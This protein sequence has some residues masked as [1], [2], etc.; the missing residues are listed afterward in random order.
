MNSVSQHLK[1]LVISLNFNPGHV[2]HMIASYKQ[3]EELNY[4][5]AYYVNHQFVKFLPP[6]SSVIC[7]GQEF[8]P[9]FMHIDIAIFLF[10]SL[11]NLSLMWKLKRNGTKIVYVFHEPLTS[12]NVYRKAGFSFLYLL[13]LQLIDCISALAVKLSNLILLPSY[14]AIDYY[15]SNS[16]YKNSNYHYLPLM[17]DDEAVDDIMSYSR[18]YFSYIGTVAADHSFNEFLEFVSWAIKENKLPGLKFLIATKS[19][20]AVPELLSSSSRVVI[21]K[22]KPMTNNEINSHYA[23]T[24]VIWNAYERTTQSGVLAKSFMFG[25]PAIMLYK[26][27]NE[28]ANDGEEVLAI[29]DNT[30]KLEILSAINSIIDNFSFYSKKCRERFLTSFYYKNFNETFEKIIK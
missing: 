30:N 1:V 18:E 8:P 6:N 26:N 12:M 29:N 22:G 17:Y 21:Y 10:P 4:D 27:L 11:N 13:K 28:F 2:S 25:T 20:F 7:A 3:C 24:Y 9:N 23:S 16:R 5:A 14:K 19:E 15:K